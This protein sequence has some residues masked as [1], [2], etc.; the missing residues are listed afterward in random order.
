MRIKSILIAANNYPTPTDPVHTFVEQLAIAISK[1][2]VKVTVIAPFRIVQHYLRHT[3]LHPR[4]RELPV[5]GGESITVMQPR[6]VTLGARFE[7]FNI[8]SAQKAISRAAK[9]LKVT[10]DVC[11]GHFWHWAYS[12]YPY[13]RKNSI[14]LF[15]NT[16][17]TPI[18]LHRICSEDM[19]KGFKNYI[20]GVVC[21]STFCK[22]ESI[23]AGLATE[24]L[25]MVRPNSIDSNLFYKKD[26]KKLRRQ[27]G[28]DENAFIVAF[29]GWYTPMKGAGVL[30]KAIDILADRDIKSFFIGSTRS[31]AIDE[32]P[33]CDGVLHTGRLPH[34]KIPDYLNMADV[35]VLP[36]LAEGSS[37]AIIEAMACGLPIVSSNLPFNWDVLNENNSI[38]VNPKNVDEI[39]SA[40]ALLKDNP[41]KRE[42]MSKAALETALGLTIDKRAEKILSFIESK[43]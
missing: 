25:C 29:T 18:I 20:S 17:E 2:G 15:V 5:E 28:F 31:G 16:S 33:S 1:Q 36:T 12:V 34:D 22:E 40:I 3:E 24:E 32:T 23:R 19:L 35:F 8:W 38:M 42:Q 10:P 21:G 41:K 30:S 6:C 4:Y 27:Y 9:R 7:K 14:P 26:K 37:N 43:Y 13:A 11:Y 39:A